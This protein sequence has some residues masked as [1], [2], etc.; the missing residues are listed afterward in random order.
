VDCPPS[1]LL[2]VTKNPR[3][4]G[5]LRNQDE[6]LVTADELALRMTITALAGVFALVGHFELQATFFAAEH[7]IEFHVM[8]MHPQTPFIWFLQY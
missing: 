3:Q 1:V 6:L 2:K 5:F 8:T 7:L 4:A